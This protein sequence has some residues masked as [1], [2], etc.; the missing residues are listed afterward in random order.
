MIDEW[1]TKYELSK[2]ENSI[3]QG[4]NAF[5]KAHMSRIRNGSLNE[6]IY[7]KEWEVGEVI[8]V[9]KIPKIDVDIPIIQGSDDVSLKL[10]IG[11]IIESDLPGQVGNCA[12]AGHRS[13]TYGKMFNRLGEIVIGDTIEINFGKRTFIYQVYEILI[14]DPKDISVLNRNN[15]DTILTLITCHPIRIANKR[16]VLHCTLAQ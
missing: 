8:G 15:R 16:L 4:I 12:L 13:Y 2:E 7:I 3:S 6:L 1:K 14:V 9:I 11:H 5:K 10:G